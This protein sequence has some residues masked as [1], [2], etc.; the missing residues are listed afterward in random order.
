MIMDMVEE[1]FRDMSEQN[2]E[3]IDITFC[4]DTLDEVIADENRNLNFE[5]RT[6]RG[7]VC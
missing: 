2:E 6:I 3:L 5:N 7:R 4:P 1:D